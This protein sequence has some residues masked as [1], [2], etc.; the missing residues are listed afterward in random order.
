MYSIHGKQTDTR[1]AHVHE[2][3]STWLP[4]PTC[5]TPTRV[6]LGVTK[7]FGEAAQENLEKRAGWNILAKKD[8]VFDSKSSI[9]KYTKLLLDFLI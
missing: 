2:S 3:L 5:W 7:D 1:C 9:T 6:G 8:L 4:P